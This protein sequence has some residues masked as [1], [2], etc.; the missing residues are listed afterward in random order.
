MMTTK[1]SDEVLEGPL[2]QR[3]IGQ[4]SRRMDL[5]YRMRVN[6]IWVKLPHVKGHRKTPSSVLTTLFLYEEPV[7]VTEYGL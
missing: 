2:R 6:R 1:H 3:K 7:Q 5:E 4:K